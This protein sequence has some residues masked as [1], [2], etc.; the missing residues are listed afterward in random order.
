MKKTEEGDRVLIGM[1]DLI[2]HH[3]IVSLI[4]V[5]DFKECDY[6]SCTQNN[7]FN[8]ENLN[9]SNLIKT[10]E[11]KEKIIEIYQRCEEMWLLIVVDS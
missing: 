11:K 4:Q 6:Y 9:Y 3:E 1:Y 2:P 8:V 7:V 10:I 5:Y